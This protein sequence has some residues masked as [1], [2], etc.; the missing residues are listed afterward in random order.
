V[1]SS[2][3]AVSTRAAQRGELRA[4]QTGAGEVG[5]GTG[6][7]LPLQVLGHGAA[8]GTHWEEGR[9]GWPWCTAGT[10]RRDFIYLY[11]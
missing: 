9:A 8:A 5:K 2:L 10:A 4:R 1:A 7:V 6:E 3:G 11:I